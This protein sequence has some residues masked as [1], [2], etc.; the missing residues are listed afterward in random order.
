MRC[1]IFS[2]ASLRWF[3]RS[4]IRRSISHSINSSTGYWS[5]VL[6]AFTFGFVPLVS[7]LWGKDSGSGIATSTFGFARLGLGFGCA[8]GCGL[9]SSFTSRFNLRH[10]YYDSHLL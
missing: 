4:T 10:L 5:W 6:V 3:L 2:L 7:A 1:N 8:L 9:G